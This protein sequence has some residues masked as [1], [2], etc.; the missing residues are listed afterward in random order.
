MSYRFIIY[1]LLAFSIGFA[2]CNKDD[3]EP[4]P[5]RTEADIFGTV[6]LFDEFQAP[7][8]NDGMV[9][10]IEKSDPL[11]AD[12]T[13]IDGNYRFKNLPFG[14]FSLLFQ[15]N[16]YGDHVRVVNHVNSVEGATDIGVSFL[17]QESNTKIPDLNL[18][19]GVT[20]VSILVTVDSVGTVDRP[21]Y[22]R[23]F[24]STDNAVSRSNYQ[25]FS[26]RLIA[27]ASVG[28]TFLSVGKIH[29][30]GFQTGDTVY[31]KAYGESFYP[32]EYFDFL[33]GYIVFPNLN[34]VSAPEEFF[35]VQ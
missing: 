31:V 17:G 24:Y 2:A 20:S 34:I 14:T 9:V 35:E 8:E 22:Y 1:I 7:L 15:K 30:M 25:V 5:N 13:D 29:E 28:E 12:T 6:S 27:T 10:T 18:D 33:L 16:G 4:D 23:L 3:E 11:I 32:N 26:N 21:R 19:L